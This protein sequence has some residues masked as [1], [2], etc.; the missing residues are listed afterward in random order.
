[1]HF[2]IEESLV[3]SNDPFESALVEDPYLQ[4]RIGCANVLSDMYALGVV[5]IDNVLMILA[6]SLD[7]DEKVRNIVTRKF[8]TGFNDCCLLAGTNVTGGQSVLNP[9]PIIGNLMSFLILFLTLFFIV[10]DLSMKQE[11]WQSQC[12]VIPISLNR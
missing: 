11:E 10:C 1:M 7:M 2:P 3:Y 9:W 6:A 4:G 12:A 5:D 8:M